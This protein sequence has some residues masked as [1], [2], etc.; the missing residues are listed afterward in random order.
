MFTDIVGYTA[1][2]GS[3]E[4]KAF[5]VL[6][7]NREIHRHIIKKYHGEWLKEMG[8]GILASFQTSSYAVRCAG[9]IQHAT[10]KE[11]I[12]LRIGIHEGEVVF[13]GG[14]VL[15]DGVNVAS[16]LEEIA[17]EG[18]INISEAVYRDIKNKAGITA[19]FIAEKKLKN[20]EEPVK[21]YRASC[22]IRIEEERIKVKEQKSK[23]PKSIIYILAGSG[24]IIV[25]FLIW[26]YIQVLT[27][28]S[29]YNKEKSVAVLPFDNESADEENLY[30]VNGMME[31]IRNN[32]ST[33]AD[34]RVIS[35][36]STEKYRE[37]LLTSKE[38]ASELKVNYLLEGTVQKQGD[39]V[40]IHAQ[41][42]DAETDDHIWSES[43][44]REIRNIFDVQSE[45]AQEIAEQ[46][47]AVITPEEMAI[48][49]TKP[50]TNLTAYDFYLRAREEHTKFW[51]DN[52]NIKALRNAISLYKAALSNDSTFS[53]AYSGL[54]RAYRGIYITDL[55]TTKIFSEFERDLYRDSILS[56]INKALFYNK[57]SEE[58]YNVKGWYYAGIQEYDSAILNFNLALEIN[59]NYSPAYDGLSRILFENKNEIIDGIR[60][61]LKAIEL[62]RGS[63]LPDLLK[64][65]GVYYEHIGFYNN[66][67][68]VYN[69][70]FQLTADT[71]TFYFQMGGAAYVRQDYKERIR[72]QRKMLEFD[73]DNFIA[74][75]F[76]TDNYFLIGEVDSAQ[77]YADRMI[78][79]RETVGMA[80]GWEM[81]YGYVLWQKGD[82]KEAMQNF[83]IQN[84]FSNQLI[85]SDNGG[86]FQFL[87][88]AQIYAITGQKE[89]AIE[90]L[91]KI[92]Y[93]TFKQRWFIVRM[94]ESPFFKEIKSD[95]RYQD[96]LNTMKLVWQEEHEKVRAWL[97]EEEMLL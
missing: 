88:L 24:V 30:F 59:P 58:A 78:E 32:L 9:E 7:K 33:I 61:K 44:R 37:T 41:L 69:Q 72:W 95:Q 38:I 74:C 5:K 66:A 53:E 16:R 36:T 4:E 81:I 2:M 12:G 52:A 17:D 93:K 84:R 34:L 11:G 80:V 31:D 29:T 14:D 54:A 18:S 87:Q 23:K 94:D 70:I 22:D 77:Y 85:E 68:E 62:E 28:R 20:V 55:Y 57:Q 82:K 35:K 96:I 25:A 27:P 19:G 49:E 26:Q 75:V 60:Y 73:P 56:L 15:G 51:L 48:L 67:I 92:D 86:D 50:T 90:Y 79:L 21:V 97:E 71:L 13:E 42:I 47:R 76:L 91:Y 39:Q 83:D 1:L 8:D 40:K 63:I 43:Y 3:D 46:L 65:L 64:E 45:I 10:N 89:K 6:R